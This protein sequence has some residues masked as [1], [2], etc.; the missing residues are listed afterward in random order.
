M[1]EIKFRGK[2]NYDGKW[3]HGY[4]TGIYQMEDGELICI[5][6]INGKD[7]LCLKETLGQYT[8]FKDKDNKEVYK[9]DIIEVSTSIDEEEITIY[10]VYWNDSALQYSLEV[11]QGVNYDD[12]L[13]DLSPSSVKVIGNIYDNPQLLTMK[14]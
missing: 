14:K 7:N 13:A 6:D 2:R 3:V 8:G 12:V 5:K 1:Q 4:Y 10:T 11:I 9:G